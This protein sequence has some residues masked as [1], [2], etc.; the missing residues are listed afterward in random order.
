M[1]SIATGKLLEGKFP[2]KQ[3][4]LVTAWAIMH[5]DALMENWKIGIAG[6]KLKKIKGLH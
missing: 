5:K 3:K 4:A 6:G 2:E 1:F